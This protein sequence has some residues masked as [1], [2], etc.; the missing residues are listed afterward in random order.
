M[1]Y[2]WDDDTN[3]RYWVEI[4]GIP[5]IGTSLE[6]PDHQINSDG[7]HGRNTWYELVHSVRKGQIVYHY[8]EREQRFVGRSVAASDAEHVKSDR[9][10]VVDLE[11]FR[12]IAASI[13]LAYMRNRSA[14]L[15]R[16]RQELKMAHPDDTIYTPFQFRGSG[17]YGMMSNYFAKLPRNVVLELFGPDGLAEGALPLAED[18]QQPPRDEGDGDVDPGTPLGSFLHPFKPKA[19]S[20]Y[21]SNVVGGRQRRSRRHERL[22]NDCAAWLAAQG[23]EPMRNAAVDLGLDDPAVIIEGKTI[24]VAWAAPVRQAVSQLYEY[25]Y[26]KVASP[27]SGLVFLSE[28]QV[29]ASWVRYLEE[30]RAIG[31]MWPSKS[32]YQLSPSARA[33]LHL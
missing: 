30:D 5:G 29:P 3:E 32:S 21:M 14:T 13:D 4:R 17:L 33:A 18:A 1:A 22:I 31:V 28:K 10:Y 20:D 15:Y 19:D 8:N 11:D 6:C 16:L 9:A 24:G 7:S 23:Y 2:W 27:A 12:P 25:R 26:F